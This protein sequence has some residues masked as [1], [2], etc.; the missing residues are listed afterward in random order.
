[1]APHGN[2]S[3]T[4]KAALT[5]IINGPS[6]RPVTDP[7]LSI[8]SPEAIREYDEQQ[9]QK[10]QPQAVGQQLLPA[11]EHLAR[12]QPADVPIRP[13]SNSSSSRKRLASDD[14]L[15]VY[16][17]KKQSKWS[18]REDALI[19][20]FR[21]KHMKWKEISDELPGRSATSCRLHY[22]NYL[23]K[24]CV[25]NE[26]RKNKLARLYKKNFW[27]QLA[28]EMEI[29]WRAAEAMHWQLGAEE[30]SRRAGVPQFS[31]ANAPNDQIVGAGSGPTLDPLKEQSD[32]GLSFLTEPSSPSPSEVALDL[33]CSKIRSIN[34]HP[35]ERPVHDQRE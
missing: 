7:M 12:I 16:P 23:E 29:P 35:V 17:A 19:I 9:Q 26:D 8:L 10:Q 13:R 24:R 18:A 32:T 11:P 34:S 21:N 6:K 2:D 20:E 30:M 14:I 5:Y 4:N 31:F 33:I 27:S 1:M 25:W 3:S 15:S 28:S 22:Q